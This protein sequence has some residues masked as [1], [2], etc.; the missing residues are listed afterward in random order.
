M[1][2]T[3]TLPCVALLLAACGD[4]ASMTPPLTAE[5]RRDP[6]ACA[7][8][9]PD[10][11]KQWSGSMHAYA[12]DDPVFRAMNARGQRETKGALGTFCLKCHAPV[13]VALGLTTD[14]LNLDT[15][16]AWARG[17]TCDFCHSVNGLDPK[18]GLSNNPL[19]LRDDGA[20]A[21]GIKDPVPNTAHASVYSALHDGAE[22]RSANLCGSCHDVLTPS[23]VPLERSLAEWQ[24][25]IY[26][27]SDSA[28]RNTCIACHMPGRDG[29]AANVEGVKLRRVHDHANA[30]IDVA[31]TDFP[32]RD[33]QRAKIQHLLDATVLTEICVVEA[34]GGADVE[35]YLENV[36][37]GHGFPSGAAADR[38]VWLSVNASAAGAPLLTV[39]DIPDGEAVPEPGADP[40]LWLLRDTIYDANDTP[41][42]NFWAAARLESVILPA[43]NGVQPGGE[44]YVNVHVPRRYRLLGGVPDRVEIAVQLQPIGID[45]LKDLVATGDLDAK[46]VAEMPTFTLGGTVQAWTRETAQSR[47]SAYSQRDALCVGFN[48]Q[49]RRN[50]PPGR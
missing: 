31:L 9:H 35:I 25:S 37:A 40:D 27:H 28:L 20:L 32:E 29:T 18:G 49:S 24:A 50:T 12:G 17:V 2:W 47:V 10:H 36:A 38:R 16:P 7:D 34:S 26:A 4:D 42:H 45:V 30:A 41:T 44:G 21:A 3:S 13:A 46:Y 48:A 5:Q 1:R 39:G 19:T 14:G 8:C 23:G 33:T 6:Q 22:V 43:P 11:L 15:L